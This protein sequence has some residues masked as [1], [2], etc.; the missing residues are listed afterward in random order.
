MLVVNLSTEEILM[1]FTTEVNLY[2][3]LGVNFAFYTLKTNA[4][5]YVFE[6]SS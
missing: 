6:I 3:K 2:G 5:V 4:I 1:E